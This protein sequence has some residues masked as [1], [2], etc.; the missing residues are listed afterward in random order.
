MSKVR[1]LNKDGLK[2]QA[3]RRFTPA[4]RE[5]YW[6]RMREMDA[7][8]RQLNREHPVRQLN[9]R[10]RTLFVRNEFIQGQAIFKG[11]R[12]FWRCLSADSALLWM[13]VTPYER[14]KVELLRRGM[15]WQW[16]KPLGAPDEHG[17]DVRPGP[18]NSLGV[19][20]GTKSASSQ[21]GLVQ[22]TPS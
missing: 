8:L 10:F 14:L 2:E 16:D 13:K 6:H 22:A 15:E 9:D 4:E 18:E 5:A 11:R 17:G 20:I 7:Q 21:P 3:R 12:G 1:W 19:G